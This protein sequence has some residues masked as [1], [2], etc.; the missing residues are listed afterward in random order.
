VKKSTLQSRL[1]YQLLAITS[2]L[3]AAIALAGADYY[4]YKAAP[5]TIIQSEPWHLSISAPGWMASMIGTV[6]LRGVNAD[7]DVGFDQI[8]SHLDMIFAMRAEASKG[9]LGMFGEF[10]YMSLGDDTE[11][12]GLIEK[13]DVR[14]D[15]YFADGALSWRVLN[16]SRLWLDLAAGTHYTNLYQRMTLHPDTLAISQASEQ[17]VNNIT[18]EL[19]DRLNHAI[20]NSEFLADLKSAIREDIGSRI[21]NSLGGEQTD[22]T[23]PIAPLGGRVRE[24]ISQLV[25]NIIQ[26]KKAA[27]EA[28]I[29]A[30][31]LKGAARRAAVQKAVNSA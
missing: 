4:D 7:V 26:A 25:Q 18:T 16:Q 3:P 8:V 9:P 31:G 13:V 29:D 27:L 22:P 24:R 15:Q 17:F 14:L 5:P 10:I 19:R 21:D 11:V 1:L 6:G 30:L 23:I 28:R 2:L 20:S 12:N